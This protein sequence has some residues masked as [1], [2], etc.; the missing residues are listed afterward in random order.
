MVA[1][2]EKEVVD[3][4]QH[5]DLQHYHARVERPGRASAA[6]RVIGFARRGGTGDHLLENWTGSSDLLPGA[7]GARAEV[8]ERGSTWLPNPNYQVAFF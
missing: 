2:Y 5:Q 7:E 3:G 1:T 4:L 6:L 8:G